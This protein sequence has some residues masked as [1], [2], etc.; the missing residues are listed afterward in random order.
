MYVDLVASVDPVTGVMPSSLIIRM[1]VVGS[2]VVIS[3]VGTPVVVVG[4]VVVGRSVD[5]THCPS[6]AKT[7]RKFHG[8]DFIFEEGS[9]PTDSQ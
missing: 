4:R 9:A 6:N 2:V 1:I 3:V 8:S 7:T 5:S